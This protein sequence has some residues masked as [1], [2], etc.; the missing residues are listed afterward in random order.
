[1]ARDGPAQETRGSIWEPG[2]TLY[3]R[4]RVDLSHSLRRCASRISADSTLCY[5]MLM[6]LSPVNIQGL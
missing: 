5:S 6:V 4:V 2:S 3:P 1:M